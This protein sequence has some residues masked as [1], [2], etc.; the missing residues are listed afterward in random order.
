M[1]EI[2]K[3]WKIKK[4]MENCFHDLWGISADENRKDKIFLVCGKAYHKERIK[5]FKRII[6]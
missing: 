1:Y 2:D 5:V 3:R 6:V 4:E